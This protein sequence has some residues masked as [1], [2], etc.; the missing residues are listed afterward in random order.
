METASTYSSIIKPSYIHACTVRV[1]FSFCVVSFSIVK[2][3]YRWR[4]LLLVIRTDSLTQLTWI[5]VCTVLSQKLLAVE[6]PLLQPQS[7]CFKLNL[8]DTLWTLLLFSN[9]HLQL[10]WNLNL[11]LEV[12]TTHNVKQFLVRAFFKFPKEAIFRKCSEWKLQVSLGKERNL[13]DL[14][15]RKK[16]L[17]PMCLLLDRARKSHPIFFSHLKKTQNIPLKTY[18]I[19]QA[20][21][22]QELNWILCTSTLVHPKSAWA[23]LR[24]KRDNSQWTK[25]MN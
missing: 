9:L 13:S 24:Y 8:N 11:A 2:K 21:V 16:H 1:L 19:I 23:T 17:N 22:L 18:R 12:A 3:R 14:E 5:E 6:C 4:W 10:S 7:P 25:E 20:T 15:C